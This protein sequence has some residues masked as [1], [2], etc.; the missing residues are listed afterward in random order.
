MMLLKIFNGASL[1][2]VQN[3]IGMVAKVLRWGAERFQWSSV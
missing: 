2:G 1:E 3:F